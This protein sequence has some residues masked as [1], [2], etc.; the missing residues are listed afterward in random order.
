VDTANQDI[1]VF[2]P[3]DTPTALPTFA[4]SVGQEGT[5][6]GNFEYP[7]GIAVDSR[8]RLYITDRENNRLQVWSF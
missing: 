3:G 5:D 4:F 7:N 2:T 6:E 8:E 1:K